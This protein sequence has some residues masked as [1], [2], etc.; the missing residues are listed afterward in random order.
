M[1]LASIVIPI[2]ES[3]YYTVPFSPD[4]E[5]YSLRFRW[6]KRIDVWH[7]DIIGSDEQIILAGLPCLLGVPGLK[8]RFMIPNFMQLGD[9][10][11]FDVKNENRDPDYLTFGD[12]VGPFY[13][14]ISDVL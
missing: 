1:S 13:L 12:S 7:V 11:I 2:N 3:P 5:N 4:G 9:I 8:Y 10:Y 6:N 14:S